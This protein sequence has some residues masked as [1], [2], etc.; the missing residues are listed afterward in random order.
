MCAIDSPVK[1]IIDVTIAYPNGEPLD[2]LSIITGN[3]VPCDTLVIYKKYSISEVPL[4]EEA[5]LNWMYQRYEEK[6]RI[7]DEFYKTGQ[8]RLNT[9]DLSHSAPHNSRQIK[10]S[11]GLFIIIRLFFFTSFCVQFYLIRAFVC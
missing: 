11:P 4:G 1:W 5:L 3:R 10:I 8:F 9:N 2:G 6:D 7:L